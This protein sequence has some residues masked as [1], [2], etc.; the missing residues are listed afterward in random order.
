MGFQSL[1]LHPRPPPRATE[2]VLERIYNAARLGLKGDSLALASGLLPEEF[3]RLTELDRAADRAVAHGHADGEKEVAEAIRDVALA[4]DVAAGKFLLKHTYK[5]VAP[6]QVNI[7]VEGRISITQ[8]L[9]EAENRVIEGRYIEL[10]HE[11]E[12]EVAELAA[13]VAQ[14]GIESYDQD[15]P[16]SAYTRAAEKPVGIRPSDWDV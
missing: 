11:S 16:E 7:S 8:A 14:I 5:Y 12:P 15:E 1:P 9:K 3:R 13:P 10:P 2:A 4:G 6:Q